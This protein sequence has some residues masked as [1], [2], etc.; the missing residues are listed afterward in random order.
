[1]SRE[2]NWKSREIGLMKQIERKY[3]LPLKGN[4]N[5]LITITMYNPT[6]IG[7]YYLTSH[8]IYVLWNKLKEDTQPQPYNHYFTRV[9]FFPPI[10][11][12]NE[13]ESQIS[14]LF[15]FHYSSASLYWKFQLSR[16]DSEL[17]WSFHLNINMFYL[18]YLF[19]N[20]LESDFINCYLF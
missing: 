15:V 10:Y 3:P 14:E 8:M 17:Q 9:S 13:S 18:K 20:S 12:N 5:L 16:A 7:L 2:T 4:L 19:L 1:M 11:V 6:K